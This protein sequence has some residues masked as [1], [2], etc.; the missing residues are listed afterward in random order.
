M[1]DVALRIALVEDNPAD[2]CLVKETLRDRGLRYE[3]THYRDGEVALKGL[4]HA[5]DTAALPDLVLLD[6]NLP[7]RSGLEVLSFL[8]RD[9]RWSA[10]PVAILTSSDSPHDRRAAQEAGATR[11]ILKLSN[12]EDFLRTL[13]QAIEELFQKQVSSSNARHQGNRI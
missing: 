13:G 3:M 10:I 7:R 4:A 6:L 12:L 11:Y 2:V 5:A 9:S 1:K 8:R